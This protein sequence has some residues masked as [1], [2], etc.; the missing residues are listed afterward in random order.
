MTDQLPRPSHSTPGRDAEADPLSELGVLAPEAAE[1]SRRLMS[2]RDHLVVLH[3]A[4][5]EVE[6]AT[7]LEARLR[8]IVEA[9]RRIGFGRVAI[10]LRDA[11]LAPTL[12]VTS[13][14][15]EDEDRQLR[16]YPA[17]G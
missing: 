10:T 8:V 6:R 1:A 16:E 5:R 3:E 4:V 13:G 12:I 14:L 2:E 7:T 9:I 11:T 15:T 17:S